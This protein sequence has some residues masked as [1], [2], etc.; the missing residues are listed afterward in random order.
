MTRSAPTL[1]PSVRG[2]PRS[3]AHRPL[4]SITMATCFGT[5]SPGIFGGRAPV[6]CG[7]GVLYSGRDRPRIP[8]RAM[9]ALP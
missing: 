2:S 3:F 6:G 4:P 7:S 5:S 1:W 9:W 8:R